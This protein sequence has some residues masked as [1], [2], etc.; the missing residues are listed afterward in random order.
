MLQSAARTDGW[1]PDRLGNK[2]W[3]DS[4]LGAPFSNFLYNPTSIHPIL[5]YFADALY[6]FTKAQDQWYS[7]WPEDPK[8]RGMA[9]YV[10]SRLLPFLLD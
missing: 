8:E 6:K 10:S 1:F 3:F 7:T 2:P 9:V 5:G 4:S